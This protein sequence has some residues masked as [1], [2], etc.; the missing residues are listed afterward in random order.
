MEHAWP[1]LRNEKMVVTSD[2]DQAAENSKLLFHRIIV[3]AVVM[4]IKI[5]YCK[6]STE[7]IEAEAESSVPWQ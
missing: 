6:G 7:R 4:I 2:D 1:H 5:M 3:L